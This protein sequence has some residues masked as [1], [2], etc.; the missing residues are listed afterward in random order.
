MDDREAIAWLDRRTG[1]GR[2]PG[3]GDRPGQGVAA[4]LD[5]M[6]AP[7]AAPDPWAGVDVGEFDPGAGGQAKQ[8]VYRRTVAAWITAMAATPEPFAEWMRWFWHGHFVSTL[9]VVKYPQLM[10]QQLRMFGELGLGDFRTLLRAVTIDPAMLIYLDGTTSRRGAV[11][12]NYGREVLEL[13]ALGIGNYTEADVRAGAEA[14][15]GWRAERPRAGSAGGATFEPRRHDDTPK[16]YLGATVHDL[17]SVIDAIVAHPACG[18]FI[19]RKLAE[20]ILGPGVDGGLVHRLAT[21]FVASGLQLR[22]LVRAILD[23]GVSAGAST[24]LLLAPVPWLATMIRTTGAPADRVMATVGARGL[25]ASGQVP[26]DAPN[27]AGWPDPRAWLSSSA[28]VGRFNMAAGIAALVPADAP[29][30][31]HAKDGDLDALAAAFGRPAGFSAPT[32]QA[33]QPL[34]AGDRTGDRILTVAM[35][36]PD[37]VLA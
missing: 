5:A 24:E 22:P 16:A 12:E 31:A 8:A 17:D 14:L 35:A 32:T 11:N 26:M 18:P 28:T 2:A 4:V 30:R 19:T 9:R 21:D 6:L 23:A 33:L 27:V 10:I 37:L 1:F 34:L 7:V 25:V 29:V 20:A 13:F 15:T 36:S 3:T